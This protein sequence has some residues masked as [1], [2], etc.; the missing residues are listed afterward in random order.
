MF[1]EKENK[2]EAAWTQNIEW[3]SECSKLQIRI[4]ELE[5]LLSLVN[6]YRQ[7]RL[8]PDRKKMFELAKELKR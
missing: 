3:V 4:A 1:E 6:D 7:G 5:E 8:H 2:L